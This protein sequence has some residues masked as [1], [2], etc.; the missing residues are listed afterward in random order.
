[1]TI[2]DIWRLR[3]EELTKADFSISEARLEAY[4]EIYRQLLTTKSYE[5]FVAEELL[6]QKMLAS[7]EKNTIEVKTEILTSKETKTIKIITVLHDCRTSGAD[8]SVY[9]NW[10]DVSDT[11][12]G[13]RGELEG[14]LRTQSYLPGLLK[15]EGLDPMNNDKDLIYVA[16]RWEEYTSDEKNSWDFQEHTVNV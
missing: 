16:E 14:W 1:M 8:V 5:E 12:E 13:I 15:Q 4:N 3:V 10:T 7:E 6:S 2:L 9:R 11:L